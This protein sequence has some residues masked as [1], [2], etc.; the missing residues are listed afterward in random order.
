MDAHRDGVV[1]LDAA[2]GGDRDFD[3][4]TLERTGHPV[5][6]CR[7]PVDGSCPLLVGGRCETFERAHGIVFKLD[8]DRVDH[9]EILRRYRDL[10]PPDMP[11]R[12]LA[13]PGDR[14]RHADLL[15][16]VEVWDHEPDVAALDGF[17]AEVEAADRLA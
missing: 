12:V 2:P 16:Q 14:A 4:D 17:A 7:G 10:A 9:R 13:R 11:I 6:V 1:L 15:A 3:R 8:L 5:S